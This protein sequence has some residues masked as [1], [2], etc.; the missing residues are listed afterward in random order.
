METPQV[1]VFLTGHHAHVGVFGK[2][3]LKLGDFLMGKGWHLT[4]NAEQSD[5][6]CAVEVPATRFGRLDI[7]NGA[8]TKGLLVVQ[9]PDVVWPP[10]SNGEALQQ[11]A[12]VLE[13]GRP[14]DGTKWP[15]VWSPS[16]RHFLAGTKNPRACL[17]AGGKLSFIAGELYGLRREVI[18]TDS[19]VDLYGQG[20]QKSTFEKCKE[21]AYQLAVL[22]TSK[23]R[24]SFNSLA[25]YFRKPKRS[26]GP[27]DDKILINSQYKVS[28][29]IE[30]S[31]SYMSE[32]LLEAI[33]AGSIPVYVGPDPSEFGIPENLFVL[34]QAN[35]DS[36]FEGVTVALAIDY[37]LW[38]KDALSFLESS[39][40][41]EGWSLSQYWNAIHLELK[42]LS[43]AN[44]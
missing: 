43:E 9:E 12:S 8:G 29:V 24:S 28:V 36:I 37:E 6:I 32:K 33:V 25:L 38:A 5:A 7:P 16:R 30:N 21:I 11:F 1:K 4:E 34:A 22:A 20:W 2:P 14:K 26:F 15:L 10:N 18:H 19:R 42:R 44:S 27:I 17:V 35:R 39:Q 23:K 3:E 40:V 13:V 31:A 41:K